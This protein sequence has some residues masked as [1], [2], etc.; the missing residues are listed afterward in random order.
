VN[1]LSISTALIIFFIFITSI[2]LGATDVFFHVLL[3]VIFIFLNQAFATF[4]E[5]INSL[6]IAFL[7]SFT[8]LL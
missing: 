2:F 4:Q 3:Q 1:P 5:S 8:S 7:N 6:S